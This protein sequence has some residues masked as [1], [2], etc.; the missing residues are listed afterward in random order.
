M[1]GKVFGE[2][3][4]GGGS[5]CALPERSPGLRP[6]PP[7]VGMTGLFSSLLARFIV[8]WQRGNALLIS[9]QRDRGFWQVEPRESDDLLHAISRC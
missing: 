7:S 1:F 3:R 6:V 5:R 9:L 8:E 4:L 2:L